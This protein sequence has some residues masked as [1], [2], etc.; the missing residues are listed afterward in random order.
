MD[1]ILGWHDVVSV[2]ITLLFIYTLANWKYQKYKGTQLGRY[3]F[4]GLHLKVI[5]CFAHFVYHQYVYG[6]GDT[7][8][9]YQ[10][11]LN[12]IQAFGQLPW[13]TFISLFQSPEHY[14]FNLLEI[15]PD[16]FYQSHNERRLT[17]I[18][19]LIG[20]LT[21]GSFLSIGLWLSF[22][23]YWGVW[24]IFKTFTTIQP[25]LAHYAAITTLFIPSIIFWSGSIS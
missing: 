12:W 22:F 5:G 11:S 16:T 15:F 13:E 8:A 9:Y 23:A 21:F 24:R 18:T 7:F 25:H 10:V 3:F 6:G 2:P 20:L 19:S 14:D 4:L 1:N 17:K